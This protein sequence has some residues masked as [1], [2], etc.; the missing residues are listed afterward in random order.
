[1]AVPERVR[2]TVR[3]EVVAPER[4]REKTPLL[5]GSMAEGSGAEILTVGNEGFKTVSL[6]VIETVA[7]LSVPI[8]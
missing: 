2:F 4:V 7:E 6:S 8:A 3:G 1:M 5:L